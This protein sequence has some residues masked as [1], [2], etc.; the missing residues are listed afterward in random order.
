M[1]INDRT[2]GLEKLAQFAPRVDMDSLF[3]AYDVFF[4]SQVNNRSSRWSA[5]INDDI[6]RLS[7]A[8]EFVRSCASLAAGHRC[9]RQ[10]FTW[11]HNKVILHAHTEQ[12]MGQRMIIDGNPL[13]LK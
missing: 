9:K 6:A 13:S 2:A 4:I 8:H 1:K 7:S 11:C 3:A 12:Q 5:V 10:C